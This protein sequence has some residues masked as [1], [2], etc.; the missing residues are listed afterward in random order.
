[1]RAAFK[2]AFT[3]HQGEPEKEDF[4]KGI[5]RNAM[6][7]TPEKK[8]GAYSRQPFGSWRFIPA[9]TETE[10]EAE[11]IDFGDVGISGRF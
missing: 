3:R 4:V 6:N 11:E 10:E 2:I 7:S 1:M 8:I 5:N 9:N